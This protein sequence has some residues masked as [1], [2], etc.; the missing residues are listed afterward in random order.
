MIL[1]LEPEFILEASAWI[2]LWDLVG[3]VCLAMETRLY[4]VPPLNPMQSVAIIKFWPIW[5]LVRI[6]QEIGHWK[7]RRKS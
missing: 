6:V 1:G 4:Q 7:K 3:L 5:F 2:L